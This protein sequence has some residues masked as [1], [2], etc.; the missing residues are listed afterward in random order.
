MNRQKRR[1]AAKQHPKAAPQDPQS[2]R[3]LEAAKQ[4]Q[5]LFGLGRYAE[6]LE[7]FNPFE[8]LTPN[9]A[10]LYQTRGLCL[11]RLGRFADA[12]ADFE[13][14]IALNAGEAETHKNLGTL[15]A[16]L[17]RME[18]AFASFDRALALRGPLESTVFGP[19]GTWVFAITLAWRP[20]AG[21]KSDHNRS[22]ALRA[23]MPLLD[24]DFQFVSLQKG[25]RDEDCAF[26]AERPDI[27]DLTSSSSISA[28]PR[29]WCAVSTW[30][31]R[32]TPA[33]F[34]SPVRVASR[35]GR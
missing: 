14:S 19:C 23:L 13:R 30:R 22:I 33:S 7:C 3:S 2:A 1:A 17:G 25:I 24:C 12:Q 4:G 26:L 27:V 35:S 6:A 20:A 16:R 9:V 11:Q 5:L 28:T 29:R 8:K 18:Q 32:S 34:I 10:P 31:S 15:H 21:H